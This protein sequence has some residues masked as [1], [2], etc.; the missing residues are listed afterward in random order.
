MNIVVTKRH[1]LKLQHIKFDFSW[2]SI[3]QCSLRT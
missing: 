3:F 1:I 2:G